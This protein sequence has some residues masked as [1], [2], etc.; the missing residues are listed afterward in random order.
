MR[1]I[2]RKRLIN[3]LKWAEKLYLWF[4]WLF[5]V[6]ILGVLIWAGISEMFFDYSKFGDKETIDSAWQLIG[7]SLVLAA[8]IFNIK[9]ELLLKEQKV[10]FPIIALMF[11]L[12]DVAIFAAFALYKAGIRNNE[13]IVIHSGQ[14]LLAAAPG[15]IALGISIMVIESIRTIL[16]RFEQFLDD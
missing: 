12:S 13:Q 8:L 7:F 2:W 1:K 16:K 10:I 3:C 15:F 14:Y 4:N 11:V 9:E 6:L 5:F